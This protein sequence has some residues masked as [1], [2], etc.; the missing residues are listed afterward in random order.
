MAP[1]LAVVR[2][3]NEAR[4]GR[5]RIRR[6]PPKG[7][8]K[9]R[10]VVAAVTAPAKDPTAD[11]RP[12][13]PAQRVW[14]G[15]DPI[16]QLVQ[17][18][19]P[20][21]QRIGDAQVGGNG[22]GLGEPG[23]DDELG[24]RGRRGDKRRVKPQKMMTAPLHRVNQADRRCY[25]RNFHGSTSLVARHVDDAVR[26]DQH[27]RSEGGKNPGR[28]RRSAATANEICAVSLMLWR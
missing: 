18:E 3:T 8:R 10:Q 14:V 5:H 6:I 20:L 26:A 2:R 12:Q 11:Q 7:A 28:G 9:R 15:A 21:G 16:R 19:R 24:H 22:H 1:M 23:A 13:Q 25:G 4:K 27:H 17:P